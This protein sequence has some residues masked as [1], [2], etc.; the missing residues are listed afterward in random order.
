MLN[1]LTYFSDCT[2]ATDCATTGRVECS[3]QT[4]E[5]TCGPCLTGYV[6]MTGN[7]NTEC[8]CEY[9]ILLFTA[10]SYYVYQTVCS[11]APDCSALNRQPCSFV[12]GT[13]G[14]CNTRHITLSLGDEGFSNIPC[15]GNNYYRQTKNNPCFITYIILCTKTCRPLH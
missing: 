3:D 2:E 7:G 4:P 10:Y 1:I 5:Q 14:P 12:A 8:I 9:K 15:F 13:C 6:G 11:G